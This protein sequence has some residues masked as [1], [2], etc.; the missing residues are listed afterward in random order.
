MAIETILISALAPA[1]L[2]MLKNLLGGIGRKWVGLSVD[3][4]IK[5]MDANVGKLEALAKL[6]N[7]YGT[8]SQWVVDLRAAFRYVSAGA[9]ILLGGA[10]IFYG[11]AN[12]NKEALD[13]GFE[14]A[15]AP[16]GFIFGERLWNNLKSK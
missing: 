16:F 9:L 2:D 15:G 4:E 8:P 11:M 13:I 1:A 3:E 14:T 5:L 6:D 12:A 7:P 10:L